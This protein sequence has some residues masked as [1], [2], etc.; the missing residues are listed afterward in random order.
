MDLWDE[1]VSW[2]QPAERP[3]TFGGA[4]EEA[5]EDFLEQ[6]G[7]VVVARGER[8]RL[9]E[10]DLIAVDGRTVVFVEVKSRRSHEA[11]H[12]VEA[13]SD[14]KQRRMS[15]LATMFL[16]RYQLTDCSA[17]FDVVAITWPD[18]SETPQIEHIRNAF[19]AVGTDSMY[20]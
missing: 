19:D 10:I 13:I 17:R 15:R 1:L 7:Y 12:P 6:L 16:Q 5:A 18:E 2:W 9:G 8:D 4:G 3:R 11:G 20:A 14:H